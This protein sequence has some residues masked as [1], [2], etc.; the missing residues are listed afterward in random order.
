MESTATTGLRIG[1]LLV[2]KGLI[3]PEELE[4]GLKEHRRTP[5]A[6]LGE[7]LVRMEFITEEQLLAALSE[8]IGIPY[9]KL[10]RALYDPEV[11]ESLPR[12]FVEKHLVLPLFKVRGTLTVAL[13]DPLDVFVTDSLKRLSGLEINTV[14]ASPEDIAS[15]IRQVANFKK[16]FL[17][18]EFIDDI[19]EG[20]IQVVEEE[21]DDID[22]IEEVAGLSPIVRLVN[23]II[24]K[25]IQERASDIHIEPD[26]GVL[27]IRYRVDGLLREGM[28]PPLQMH[29]AVVSRIKI[30]ADLDISVRRAPQDGRMRVMMDNRLIDLRVS[31]LP[32]YHGEK[33]VI[34]VLDKEA[35]LKDLAK[36]GF[37]VKML[38]SFE[39]L[40][41]RPNGIILVTGPT[42]SGKTTTLYS[43]LNTINSVEKNICTVENPIEY[44]L[45]FINQVQVNEKAGLDFAGALRSLLRQDPDVVTV[46]ESA[47]AK[48]LRSRFRPRSRGISCS[49]R[50][51]PTTRWGP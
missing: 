28:R 20:D 36:L 49:R 26:E 27:R 23:F 9:I 40:I 10:E 8:Q 13:G 18:D 43:A 14:V 7:T 41:R 50:C 12:D 34:R 37:S 46:G 25:G 31:I 45:K 16:A 5:F 22:K 51:T 19:S 24:Y 48:R 15:G 1:D 3:T 17:L 30:M 33:V 39:R 35:M 47:I 11:F 2:A 29:A 6:K 32:T 38:E 21:V 42:G 44:N 4:E